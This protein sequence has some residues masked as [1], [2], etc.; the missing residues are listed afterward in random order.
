M[1]G[2]LHV[3]PNSRRSGERS[4]RVWD[5]RISDEGKKPTLD[6]AE[7]KANAWVGF[8]I[9]RGSDSMLNEPGFRIYSSGPSRRRLEGSLGLARFRVGGSRLCLAGGTYWLR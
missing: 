5:E 8:F 7:N 1:S 2:D 9:G 4:I 3:L 6:I